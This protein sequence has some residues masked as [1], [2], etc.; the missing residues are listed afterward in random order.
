MAK[1]IFLFD[2]DGTI[3]TEDI[4]DGKC[5][6]KLMKKFKIKLNKFHQFFVRQDGGIINISFLR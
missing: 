1:K 6:I 3:V 4:L 2:F 5:K